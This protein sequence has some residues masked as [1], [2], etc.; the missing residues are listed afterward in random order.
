MEGPAASALYPT[1]DQPGCGV[2][3]VGGGVGTGAAVWEDPEPTVAHPDLLNVAG[4]ES[5]GSAGGIEDWAVV[6]LAVD[7]E[8]AGLASLIPAA[9]ASLRSSF[10][11]RLRSFS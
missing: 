1:A 6:R 5:T 9:L 3:K 10:S 7:V 8:A 4:L 11:S 2:F